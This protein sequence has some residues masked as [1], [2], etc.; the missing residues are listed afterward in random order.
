[1]S[2]TS[3]A[4]MIMNVIERFFVIRPLTIQYRRSEVVY[5]CQYRQK[6]CIIALLTKIMS[7]YNY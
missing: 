1:M 2:P 4:L 6:L 3:P 5:S 7:N